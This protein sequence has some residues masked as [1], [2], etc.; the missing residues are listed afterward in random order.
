MRNWQPA[1]LG[2]LECRKDFP[3]GREWN[4]KFYKTKS[5]PYLCRR[6]G[7]DR[8]GDGLRVLLLKEAGQKITYDAEVDALYVQF[9]ETAVTTEHLAEGIAAGY[10]AQG[11]EAQFAE[12]ARLEATIRGNFGERDNAVLLPPL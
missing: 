11:R 9:L 1:E 4:K 5:P 12:S 7:Y 3:Y 8:G 10:D 6:S 2:R